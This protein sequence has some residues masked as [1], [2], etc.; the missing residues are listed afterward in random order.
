MPRKYEHGG[1]RGPAGVAEW[2]YIAVLDDAQQPI[3]RLSGR[4]TT[5]YEAL[6]VLRWIRRRNP[7]ARL[8]RELVHRVIE[9]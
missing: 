1:Y 3:E 2:F 4:Y 5:R 8:V 7:N 9:E 6:P